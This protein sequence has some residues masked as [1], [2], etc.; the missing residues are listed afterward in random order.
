V[1][2][3][4]ISQ[5]HIEQSTADGS[6]RYHGPERALTDACVTWLLSYC[7]S[8][9]DLSQKDCIK[10]RT[11]SEKHCAILLIRQ[12]PLTCCGTWYLAPMCT[13]IRV[14]PSWM[15]A[16]SSASHDGL[17]ICSACSGWEKVTH[18]SSV[19]DRHPRVALPRRMLVVH[20]ITITCSVN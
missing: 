1:V 16:S 11:D 9:H 18:Q 6:H 8:H 19:G 20:A 7:C 5:A 13:S 12:Q 2:K 15:S 14:Q 4:L 17:E 3:A 10:P